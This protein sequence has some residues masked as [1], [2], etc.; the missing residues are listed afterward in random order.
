MYDILI[1]LRELYK[2]SYVRTIFNFYIINDSDFF[3]DFSKLIGDQ[4][5]VV[6]DFS[7]LFST[8]KSE[9]SQEEFDFYKNQID[10]I[11]YCLINNTQILKNLDGFDEPSK[12]KIVEI[13][14]DSN[15]I[16]N[17]DVNKISNEKINF[18]IL[19]PSDNSEKLINFILFH[20]NVIGSYQ[21]TMNKKIKTNY[22]EMSKI[23][24]NKPINV[25]SGIL[26]NDL[27]KNEIRFK[28]ETPWIK[29][30]SSALTINLN[31]EKIIV[32]GR[33][34]L[35]QSIDITL[36]SK[37]CLIIFKNGTVHILNSKNN[38]FTFLDFLKNILSS[39]ALVSFLI[40]I[41]FKNKD[42]EHILYKQAKK[43]FKMITNP[44]LT[45]DEILDFFKL[46]EFPFNKL[47]LGIL[48]LTYLTDKI[49]KNIFSIKNKKIKIYPESRI[50]LISLNSLE[51]I[52][53]TI[54]E[55]ETIKK[56]IFEKEDF[57]TSINPFIDDVS[58]IE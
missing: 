13:D 35:T 9:W 53:S 11:N 45:E 17:Y 8:L 36:K 39:L 44:N 49:F 6:R 25:F 28:K 14:E 56:N 7:Q 20:K 5:S 40:L 31:Y 1:R 32:G 51:E 4:I 43:N 52:N 42:P 16:L 27:Q 19:E 37:T 18:R 57:L 58:F 38:E 15:V 24:L 26:E 46:D 29:H 50:N 54:K 22:G 48:N 23:V 33:T 2:D 34:G 30:I 47:R 21:K 41:I 3:S 10:L 12:A 55:F